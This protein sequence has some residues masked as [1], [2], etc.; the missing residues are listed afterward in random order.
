MN[1]LVQLVSFRLVCVSVVAAVAGLGEPLLDTSALFCVLSQP[2]FSKVEELEGEQ[3]MQG[4]LMH[5]PKQVK[6]QLNSAAPV[7]LMI[8]AVTLI[9]ILTTPILAWPVLLLVAS[10]VT[11]TC[12]NS[13]SNMAPPLLLHHFPFLIPPT[14]PPPALSLTSPTCPRLEK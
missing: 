11:F 14:S 13:N 10:Y 6:R 4:L 7:M 3:R 2:L 12:Q 5:W 9:L 8:S 1:W